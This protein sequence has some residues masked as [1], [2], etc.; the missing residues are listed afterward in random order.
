MQRRAVLHGATALASLAALAAL[1]PAWADEAPAPA[2]APAPG[3]DWFVFL[4]RGIPTPPD[5]ARV[6]AM[7]K[8]HIDNFG[9]LFAAGKLF[10]A[11]PMRDPTQLKRGIV[12]V[13]APDLDTLRH[14]F[15][16][17][18]YVALGHMTLNAQP[19][20]VRKAL[21]TTG[22]NLQKIVENRIVMLSGAAALRPEE[23]QQLEA[24]LQALVDDGTLGA[25]YAMQA[26]PIDHV[27]FR[28]GN[29]EAPLQ[30]ALAGLPGR[31][32]ER[33]Q[34]AVWGQWFAEGVVR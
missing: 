22:L 3:R 11:G 20:I 14:Y 13:R 12:V 17:D 19:C 15:D 1:P 2:P 30:A 23:R 26:G 32:D 8:G 9:R 7:Q 29:D 21:N 33:L 28:A 18:E 4:E 5:K 34:A 6:T 25:W 24:A 10:A 27:L 31:T 16:E